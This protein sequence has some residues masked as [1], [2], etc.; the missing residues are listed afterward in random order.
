MN[1][2]N[3][4]LLDKLSTH[5][6]IELTFFSS[7]NELGLIQIII[8][9]NSKYI[10]L[11]EIHD[12]EKMIR[13]HNDLEINIPGIDVACNLL[14]KINKLQEELICTKNRLRRYEN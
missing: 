9:E 14:K 6:K 5:Y 10:H 3:L 13:M 8:I 12:L 7:L 4:V 1:I 11:N 2:E